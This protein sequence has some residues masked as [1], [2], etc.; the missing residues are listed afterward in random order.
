MNALLG[1]GDL[2][3][4]VELLR[5]IL[6]ILNGTAMGRR[7][8]AAK[9]GGV[10]GLEIIDG[11]KHAFVLADDVGGAALNERRHFGGGELGAGG[12]AKGRN[13]QDLRRLETLIA[14]FIVFASGEGVFN[15]GIHDEETDIVRKGNGRDRL[16]AAIQID[17]V[18]LLA[19]DGGNLVEQAAAHADKFILSLAAKLGQIERGNLDAK[20]PSQKHGGGNLN[21]GGTGKPGAQRQGAGEVG[22][23]AGDRVAGILQDP[24]DTQRIVGPAVAGGDFLDVDGHHAGNALAGQDDL[25]VIAAL[26]LGGYPEVDRGG[27]HHPAIVISVITEKFHTAR[28]KGRSELHRIA[29]GYTKA[30]APAITGRWLAKDRRSGK[31]RTQSKKAMSDTNAEA[32]SSTA[33]KKLESGTEHAKKALDAASEASKTVGDTVKKQ[34]QAAYETGREHLTAAAKDLS[35]AASAKYEEIRGQAQSKAEDY[36]GRAKAA[37]DDATAKAQ[38]FQGDAESYIRENPLKAVGIALGVG[39]VLGVIF[40]R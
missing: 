19:E 34:A 22:F 30:L 11:G 28:S 23:E 14:A 9:G 25:A 8:E 40:R 32:K 20:E 24:G 27:K 6:K 39:F 33:S 15:T 26:P 29:H 7:H 1:A 2:D 3:E 5:A 31:F 18:I 36:K 17:G 16:G 35:E 4:G 13:T 12:I 38:D 37:I 10:A 21:S